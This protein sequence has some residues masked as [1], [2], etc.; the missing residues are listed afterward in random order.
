MIR[1]TRSPLRSTLGFEDYIIYEE[2]SEIEKD[3]LEWYKLNASDY[4]EYLPLTFEILGC[5]ENLERE[6]LYQSLDIRPGQTI[7]EVG[8]GTGR[9]S[10]EI[11]KRLGPN[12][13]LVAQDISP[14]ILTVCQE[15]YK[16]NVV[17]TFPV[18]FIISN[19]NSLPF[20]NE[21]FDRVFHFGGLNTFGDIP[22]A[23]LEFQRVTKNGG[24][25]LV[26]DE[27]IAPWLRNSR[28]GAI[29]GATNPQY[30][31]QPPLDDIPESA[32]DVNLRW[33]CSGAFYYIFYNVN[34]F[35]HSATNFD[36]EI[37]GIRGGTPRKRLDGVLEGVSPELK[38]EVYERA[39]SIGTS[40]VNF[41]ER[42]LR[43]YLE[44]NL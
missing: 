14:E 36:V 2:L 15:K 7:L 12:G 30:L 27:G 3:F 38:Y 40:R 20:P 35:S 19:A 17:E 24:I 5:D 6:K 11:S 21:T 31:N 39:K 9:D 32:S 1:K 16:K 10:I 41:I 34:H 8:A 37:P 43:H 4:D 42:A 28:F 23:L 29:L 44:N 26:G 22:S 25:V 18:E 13:L 33:F